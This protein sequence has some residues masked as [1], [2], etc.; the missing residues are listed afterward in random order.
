MEV[1]K[2]MVKFKN[3]QEFIRKRDLLYYFC[4]LHNL[5]LKIIYDEKTHLM[6][7]KIED[8][9]EIESKRNKN[10]ID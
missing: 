3:N 1:K 2:I 10:K 6:I 7:F 4:M 8:G 5:E 9:K